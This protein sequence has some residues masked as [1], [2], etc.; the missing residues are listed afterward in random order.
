[1]N[2]KFLEAERGNKN[3][4]ENGKRGGD[5]NRVKNIIE[6]RSREQKESGEGNKNSRENAKRAR[7]KV[8]REETKREKKI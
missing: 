6:G 5:W 3:G 4:E 1:V 7:E 8:K 2:V